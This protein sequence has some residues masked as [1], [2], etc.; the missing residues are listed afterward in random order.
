M[1]NTG[2]ISVRYKTHLGFPFHK[3]RFV[4]IWKKYLG[5][6]SVEVRLRS[7]AS[8]TLIHQ[9]QVVLVLSEKPGIRL[10]MTQERT[11]AIQSRING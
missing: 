2:V 3:S 10:P 5:G 8:D 9:I 7:T 6:S 1:G 4:R 11:L